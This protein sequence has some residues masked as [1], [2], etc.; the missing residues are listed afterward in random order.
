M[1]IEMRVYD[2]HYNSFGIATIF[3]TSY[4]SALNQFKDWYKE[5]FNDDNYDITKIEIKG[6]EPVL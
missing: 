5:K 3:A 1:K 6:S 4:E 2:V